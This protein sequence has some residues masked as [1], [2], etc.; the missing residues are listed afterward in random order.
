[1]KKVVL[2]GVCMLAIT[3]SLS[4]YSS[5]KE[6][7]NQKN[8]VTSPVIKDPKT[9]GSKAGLGSDD[10][11]LTDSS[12]TFSSNL[13]IEGKIYYEEYAK[14]YK[15]KNQGSEKFFKV[16]KVLFALDTSMLSGGIVVSSLKVSPDTADCWN[17]L[18]GETEM[19]E[20]NRQFPELS[21]DTLMDGHY[22]ITVCPTEQP[23]FVLR[24]KIANKESFKKE[25]ENMCNASNN[26]KEP[27]LNKK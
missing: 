2:V 7:L 13:D 5:K 24:T 20:S 10:F 23:C 3:L 18:Y 15:L 19:Y 8:V 25:F 17:T 16:T 1:M 4:S 12:F 11:F 14:R 22:Y 6:K 26:I 21:T 9:L 27:Y